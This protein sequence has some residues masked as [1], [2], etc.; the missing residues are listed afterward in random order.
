MNEWV[1][2]G[3]KAEYE[4]SLTTN[5]SLFTDLLMWRVH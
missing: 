3:T 1:K 4:Y 2:N 5:G